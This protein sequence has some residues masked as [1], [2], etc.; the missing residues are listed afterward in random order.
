VTKA[1][2]SHDLNVS[3]A[4][5][6]DT[7]RPFLLKTYPVDDAEF[8][9]IES[10][11]VKRWRWQYFR[12]KLRRLLLG[13]TKRV[14]RVQH[15]YT[16]GWSTDQYPGSVAV[17]R[18]RHLLRWGREHLETSGWGEKRVHLLLFSKVM[19]QLRPASVLEVGCGNG[20]MLMMLSIMHPDVRFMGIELTDT[21]VS[22]A[23]KMQALP[24]LPTTMLDF[25]PV[26]ARDP[27]AFKTVC[28][29]RGN[30]ATLPFD[31]GSFDLVMTS[32]ALEQMDDVKE[33]VLKEIARVSRR[34][35]VMIEPFPD[36]NTT[37]IRHYYTRA[38]DY[39][40]ATVDSLPA[41]GLRPVLTFSD[42]PSKITRGAGLVLSE[43]A[44]K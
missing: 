30:A 41:Y 42:F 28:F 16:R 17:A 33:Q 27:L 15:D 21:G 38:R 32:L 31:T 34:H 39:F 22:A 18:S 37:P 40:S 12:S 43:V 6:L 8:Q 20:A 13:S 35:T 29:D 23:Q 24:T 1:A 4:E 2:D 9:A 3:R 7:L 19:Q 26:P 10:L 36:F 5:I 44:G 14:W 25:L 11:T